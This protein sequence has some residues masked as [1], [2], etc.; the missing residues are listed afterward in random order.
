MNLI[1]QGSGYVFIVLNYFEGFYIMYAVSCMAGVP[2]NVAMI[3]VTSTEQQQQQ[4]IQYHHL[5]KDF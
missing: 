4:Q 2:V 5:P 1:I 3:V